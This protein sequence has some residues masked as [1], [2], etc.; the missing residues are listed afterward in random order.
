MKTFIYFRG[1]RNLRIYILSDITTSMNQ[2]DERK[3]NWHKMG[4]PVTLKPEDRR[5]QYYAF[6]VSPNERKL[7]DAV[8]D[9]YQWRDYCVLFAGYLKALSEKKSIPEPFDT[10][11]K[12]FRKAFVEGISN[13][14]E[15]KE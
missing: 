13:A 10:P 9:A 12:I 7:L 6:R 3:V 5:A 15:P 4:R 14:L 8:G 1:E 2:A 11:E